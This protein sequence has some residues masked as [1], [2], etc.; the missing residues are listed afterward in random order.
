MLGEEALERL[1][2]VVK[3][4]EQATLAIT[5]GVLPHVL[6][7]ALFYLPVL[8]RPEI[9]LIKTGFFVFVHFDLIISSIST[10]FLNNRLHMLSV[11]HFIICIFLLL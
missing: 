6:S 10:V 3:G 11:Y 9:F 2:E 8:H 7:V 1:A 5:E 4:P